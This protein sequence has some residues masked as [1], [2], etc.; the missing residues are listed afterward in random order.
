YHIL[1]KRAPYKYIYDPPVDP[2][3]NGVPPPDPPVDS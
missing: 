3:V 1:N 2:P